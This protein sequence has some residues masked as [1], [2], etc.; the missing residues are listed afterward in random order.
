L[1]CIYPVLGSLI[2]FDIDHILS[3]KEGNSQ[4]RYLIHLGDPG[5]SQ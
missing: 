5:Q 2:F 3:L 4:E 1:N